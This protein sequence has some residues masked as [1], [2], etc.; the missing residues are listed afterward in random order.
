MPDAAAATTVGQRISALRGAMS[1]E[2]LAEKSG[3]SK[4]HLWNIEQG[5]K[6][7]TT[8]VLEKIA[9][10]LGVTLRELMPDPQPTRKPTNIAD[11][12]ERIAQPGRLHAADREIPVIGQVKGGRGLM[13]QENWTGENVLTRDPR[14]EFAF[15]VRGDSMSPAA[16]PGDLAICRR[17]A[18]PEE[19]ADGRMVIAV[20]D[21]EA[22][23]KYLAKSH[24]PNGEPLY[25]LKSADDEKHPPITCGADCHIQAE[26]IHIQGRAPT[27]HEREAPVALAES[28]NPAPPP[29]EPPAPVPAHAQAPPGPEESTE[30]VL[31]RVVQQLADSILLQRQTEQLRAQNDTLRIERVDSIQAAANLKAQEN[32]EKALSDLRM[33]GPRT[34]G[35]EGRAPGAG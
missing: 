11:L 29:E 19:V 6:D 33:I 7:P 8:G 35:G 26:V 5:R 34:S 18:G 2:K 20:V 23:I 13:A 22:V 24:G 15:E 4:S 27:L 1:L 28:D 31:R 32:V 17:V 21:D 30:A 3:V 10:A 12:R 14:A 25:L 16:E 9:E